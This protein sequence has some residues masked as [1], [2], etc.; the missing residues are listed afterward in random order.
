MPGIV[1]ESPLLQEDF[2]KKKKS[3]DI[4][5]VDAV[6][7]SRRMQH[8]AGTGTESQELLNHGASWWKLKTR[9]S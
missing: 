6:S 4:K 8:S 2:S 3:L 9:Q 7:P 5:R 1:C